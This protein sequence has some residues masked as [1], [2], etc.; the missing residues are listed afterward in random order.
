MARCNLRHCLFIAPAIA[1][2]IS[3]AIISAS[4][5]QDSGIAPL[6]NANAPNANASSANQGFYTT[7]KID[8]AFTSPSSA[9]A[10]ASAASTASDESQ[11]SLPPNTPFGKSNASNS[12]QPAPYA[13]APF[14]APVPAT[15]Q[16]IPSQYSP[17]VPFG[18]ASAEFSAPLP[19]GSRDVTSAPV[20]SVVSSSEQTPAISAPENP[21]LYPPK[22]PTEPTAQ[23]TP[24]FESSVAGS[25]SNITGVKL[26]VLNKVTTQVTSLDAAINAIA[27][28][29]NLEI[30]AKSC[31]NSAPSSRSD[32]AALIEVRS[33]KV[34]EDPKLIFNG[35]MYASSP[36]LVSLESPVYDISV[37]ECSIAKPTN[38][39]ETP[40]KTLPDK[41]KQVK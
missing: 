41:R 30:T 27:R 7:K 24:I 29:G 31:R 13:S 10:S 18:K 38:A 4:V 11:S 36:S 22:D 12:L 2:Y 16:A 37:V 40:S 26:R 23:T 28:F 33:F 35:W 9:S 32:V 5:A 39:S 17:A 15:A 34:N 20:D 6:P 1:L 21:D 19:R 14:A 3:T 8:D 25:N